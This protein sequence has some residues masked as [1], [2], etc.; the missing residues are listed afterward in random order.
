MELNGTERTV[1]P[2]LGVADR[3]AF[4][5]SRVVLVIED[6][7]LTRK[8]VHFLLGSEG[9][10]V[11]EA[12]DGREAIERVSK[13]PPDLILQDLLLP[14]MDGFE[15]L[16]RLRA[17]PEAMDVPIIAVSGCL[18]RLEHGRAVAEGF[19]DFLPKPVERQRLLQVVRAYL[20]GLAEHKEKIGQGR[21]VLVVDDDPVQLKLA[22]VL[23][24]EL[25]FGVVIARDGVEALDVLRRG[26][27]DAV[28]SD[29]LMPRI[30]GF[31]LSAEIRKDPLLAQVPVILVSSNYIEEV[32]RQ[33][34]G[35]MGASA[36]VVRTPDLGDA[37]RAIRENLDTPP[38]TPT[39]I[40][41][42]PAEY[43]DRIL[44]QLE[45]QAAANIVFAHRSSMHASMLSVMAGIS[46]AL[47]R[48][49]TVEGVLPDI[50]LSLLDA[51]GVSKG[52]LFTKTRRRPD[53][54]APTEEFSLGAS[55]GYSESGK[56]DLTAFLGHPEI[57]ERTVALNVPFVIGSSTA[58]DPAARQLLNRSGGA[59]ALLVPLTADNECLGM[60]LFVSNARDFTESDWIPFARMMS[61][62]IGQAL[63]L[64][65]A[66]S[67][68]AASETRH[69]ALL[70][71]AHDG[72][73]IVD[74][75]GRIQEANPAMAK[76]LGRS[77][78]E[79]V[80]SL[81]WSFMAPDDLAAARVE[82]ARMQGEGTIRSEGRRF[83]RAD[84]TI[85][86]F[87]I[88]GSALVLEGEPVMLGIFRDTTERQRADIEIRLL[89]SLALAASEAPD[90]ASAFDVVLRMICE[91]TR[92]SFGAAWMPR[93]DA[94]VLE[95]RRQWTRPADRE[96]FAP[97]V[98]PSFARGEGILGRVWAS[99]TA[100]WI[101]DLSTETNC[102]RSEA[103]S[104]RGI[105]AVV[106]VPILAEDEVIAIL[107]FFTD[108]DGGGEDRGLRL[109]SACAS[110]IGS[111]LARKRAEDS[112]VE[113]VR[114]ATLAAEVGLALTQADDLRVIL[115]SCTESIVHHLGAASARIWTL[116]PRDKVLELQASAGMHTHTD[117]PQQRVAVG[118]SE[119][120]LIAEERK[121]YVSND[122]HSD[123]RIGDP[124]WA[125]REGMVAFAGH[126]LLVA[127]ELVG[128]MALFSRQPLNDATLKGLA[129]IADAVAVGI[130]RKLVE[131]ANAM[132]EGQLRQS[133]KM[134]AVGRLAGGVAHDFNN[135]LS[136]IL[137]YAELLLLDL[138][139][140]DPVREDMEEIRKAG[141]RAAD[142]T[143]QL[144]MFSR[145][146]VL[147]PKVLDLNDV[148]VGMDKMLQRILG[149]DVDLVSLTA[150][151]LG[152]V[153]AD[154]GSIEQVIMNLVVNARDAMPTGGKLTIETANVVLDEAYTRTHLGAKPG[155]YV[156][157]AVTDT[158]I[159]M[160][161]ATQSRMFE[162]FFTTRE[163][164]K[165]TG[166]G[167]STVFGIVQQSGGTIWVYSEPGRGTT[168]KVHLPRVDAAVEAIEQ[169]EAP[170]TLHGSETILL[171]EDDDQVRLVAR[172]ILRRHG[173]SVLEARNGGEA[174]LLSENHPGVIH[175]LLSDVVMPEMSGPEL[176]KRL[177]VGRPE[178]KILCMS[179]YTDDSIVRHGVLEAKVAYLQKPVTPGT[180]TRKVREV[181]ATRSRVV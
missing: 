84:G 67:R 73:G 30:D 26:G 122:V 9:F 179:G 138:K 55:V 62:Q 59:S 75:E 83:I 31:R 88:A 108:G 119:I 96:R 80:G 125:Q 52:A 19:T 155:P 153:R 124:E 147:E 81:V 130:Q 170:D 154:P 78:Q 162:P 22:R 104:Q 21:R 127:G 23:L 150:D 95:C 156:M 177:A 140:G 117:D 45:R 50:L 53:G 91:S 10:T 48:Q 16:G 35:S 174:L 49:H 69:R 92:W 136:V 100:M 65:R 44:R 161:K 173:Y 93:L 12:S 11:I 5:N 158:G 109:A 135:V 46:D 40:H 61:L 171:V 144:L 101:H 60:L 29:I 167:L 143:R 132:L 102:S 71:G 41:P 76:L 121:P 85:V 164:G 97:L 105:H 6:N 38:R 89:H 129:S 28:L 14:D 24:I 139:P 68:L 42:E 141:K 107:E 94:A 149:A 1:V 148:L 47:T 166:L 114:V 165:G 20:P 172:G 56:S 159:G 57:F 77:Q 176:A 115:Q 33:V 25:G 18:S 106:A 86:V 118:K 157:L 123:P 133:Q 64:N 163:K 181:L 66:F 51:S 99:Q 146:Q 13:T 74:K 2:E 4:L 82:F 43:H 111:V 134:E 128:V 7:A 175:L 72:I 152:R 142:L 87:E 37:V 126:P 110:Q 160:D 32:D 98:Q 137:S 15:L 36:F 58:G 3:A 169:V 112:L 63:A 151:R 8:L 113:R 103:A 180:L 168:F 79:L 145:Q 34:A 27:I 120:G 90:L 39:S 70:A 54:S 17:L 131:R 178:M 116:N